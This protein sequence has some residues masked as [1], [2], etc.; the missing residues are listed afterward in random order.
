MFKKLIKKYLPDP[1]ALR[2]HP[3]MQRFD[4]FLHDGNLWHL[5]RR[6]VRNAFAVGLFAALMPM[7]GQTVLATALAIWARGNIPVAVALCWL[8]NPLTMA[9]I[10]YLCYNLGS[11]VLQRPP[12][13]VEFQA[14]SEWLLSSVEAIGWPFLVGSLVFASAVSV[15]AYYLVNGVWIGSVRRSRRLKQRQ[16]L[17]P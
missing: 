11:F 16:S 14:S 1:A 2:Q 8:T 5:N 4:R 6:S 3:S 15:A 13:D 12:L 9:P 17:K 7:P 10:F